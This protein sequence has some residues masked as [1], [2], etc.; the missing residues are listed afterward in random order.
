MTTNFFALD[1]EA[2]SVVTGGADKPA[3]PQQQQPQTQQPQTQQPRPQPQPQ[4]QPHGNSDTQ[5]ITNTARCARVG[6]PILGAL[7]G[8]FTPTPAY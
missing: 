4:P 8:I 5:W 3:Q 7:C 6:G 1:L 2:L